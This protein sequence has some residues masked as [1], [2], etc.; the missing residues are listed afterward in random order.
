MF[1]IRT[2]SKDGAKL[3]VPWSIFTFKAPVV[4]THCMVFELWA[5]AG[6]CRAPMHLERRRCPFDHTTLLLLHIERRCCHPIVP[7]LT[8][9]PRTATLSRRRLR[10]FN[11]P[12]H[13]LAHVFLEVQDLGTRLCRS[14]VYF[15]AFILAICLPWLNRKAIHLTRWREEMRKGFGS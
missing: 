15:H 10:F 1:P 11:L 12:Q 8:S 14:F 6:F 4:K 3:S 13:N 9:A 2:G 5:A 7:D